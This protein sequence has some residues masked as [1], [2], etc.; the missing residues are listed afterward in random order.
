MAWASECVVQRYIANPLLINNRKWDMRVYVMIHG[1][2][3]MKAYLATD[4]GLARFCTEDYDTS[5]PNNIFSHLTNYSLNKN[6]DGYVK[7]QALDET[8]DENNTKISLD[9]VWK[10]IQ[11]QNPEIDIETD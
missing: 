9:L 11:K 2:N 3:P 7:D 10:L 5:D 4:F 8:D 6:S 1:I